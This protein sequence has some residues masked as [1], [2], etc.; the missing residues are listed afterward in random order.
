MIENVHNQLELFKKIFELTQK[1]AQET[2][3]VKN[4]DEWESFLAEREK[5]I[6]QIR[7]FQRKRIEFSLPA[8][9][10]EALKELNAEIEEIRS[11][12]QKINLLDQKIG[13]NL[14]AEKIKISEIIRKIHHGHRTLQG[15][16]PQR[17][18]IPRYCDIKG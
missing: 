10:S 7:K 5:I 15:Y 11:L 12:H 2:L 16:S 3:D 13:E 6:N 1:K 17:T 18:Y 9:D 4:L 8:P 14:R